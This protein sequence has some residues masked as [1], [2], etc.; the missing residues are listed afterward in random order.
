MRASLFLPPLGDQL[1]QLP[2]FAGADL[3]GGQ[4]VA[5]HVGQ[6]AFKHAVDQVVGQALGGV[7]FADGGGVDEAPPLVLVRQQAGVPCQLLCTLM[8]A[9]MIG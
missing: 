7:P 1:F 6:A 9:D 8:T 3:A 4:Q 2:Q 5:D